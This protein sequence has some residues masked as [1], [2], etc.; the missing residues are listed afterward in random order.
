MATT[1]GSNLLDAT[2]ATVIIHKA[3]VI[4]IAKDQEK[5]IHEKLRRNGDEIPKYE[6]LEIIGKGAYGRVFKWYGYPLQ[7]ASRRFVSMPQV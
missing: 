1:H 7:D 6:F 3:E 4:Q 5:V 2:S